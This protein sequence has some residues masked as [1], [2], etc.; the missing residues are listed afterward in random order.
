MTGPDFHLSVCM[1][2]YNHEK[3]IRDA[4]EGVMIQKTDFD[5]EIIIANDC[6]SDNT[7]NLVN[8]YIQNHSK[9]SSIKYYRQDNN[10][11]AIPNFIFALNQ[12]T[13]KYIALC[14]G[15][16]Y[17]TDPYKLQKQVDFLEANLDYSACFHLTKNIYQNNS[18]ESFIYPKKHGRKDTYYFEDMLKDNYI[19]TCSIM[20]RWQ[21]YD[22]TLPKWINGGI[23]GDYPLHLLHSVCGKIKLIPEVMSCYRIHS[24]GVWSSK[25]TSAF[26]IFEYRIWL[27]NNINSYSKKLYNKQITKHNKR[28]V[29]S[30]FKFSLKK[31]NFK[32]FLKSLK[33]FL[34]GK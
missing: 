27:F 8:E 34:I 21:F 5:Y 2:T 10:I 29:L 6:S 7:D 28:V 23:T 1:I 4:I 17:W 25:R 33:Y 32:L 9:G 24:S 3:Y 12:C 18:K 22:K 14:E 26:T 11:G 20:Y 19:N 15:D 13:G 16:D 30:M 31:L